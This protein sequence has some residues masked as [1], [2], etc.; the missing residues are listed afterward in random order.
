M[1]G[2]IESY[3][4]E[5]LCEKNDADVLPYGCH[6]PCHHTPVAKLLSVILLKLKLTFSSGEQLVLFLVK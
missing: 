4:Y 6:V 5:V 1:S 3:A 2:L